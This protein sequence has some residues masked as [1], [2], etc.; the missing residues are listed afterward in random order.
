MSILV[1]V[2]VNSISIRNGLAGNE[3]SERWLDIKL[4]YGMFKN[5]LKLEGVLD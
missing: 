3:N 1:E 5:N 4:N 2:W